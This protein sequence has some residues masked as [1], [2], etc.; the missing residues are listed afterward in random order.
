MKK[1]LH[2]LKNL[3]EIKIETKELLDVQLRKNMIKGKKKFKILL[4]VDWKISMLEERQITLKN[5]TKGK[6]F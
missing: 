5:K 6:S 4:M 1:S 3:K 2:K